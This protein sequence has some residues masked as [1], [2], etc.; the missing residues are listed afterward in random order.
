[1]GMKQRCRRQTA[2]LVG[3]LVFAAA[4][5]TVPPVSPALAQ[6]PPETKQEFVAGLLDFAAAASGTYGDEGQRLLS[7]LAAMEN[8]LI[9]WD[10][11]VWVYET[12]IK[13]KIDDG[14]SNDRR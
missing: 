11:Q 13:S 1:M 2:E 9:K 10:A 7:A 3:S 14:R 4:A 12:F 8:G 5:V 6:S